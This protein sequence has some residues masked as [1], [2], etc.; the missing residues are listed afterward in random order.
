MRLSSEDIINYRP[1]SSCLI[2]IPHLD[3]LEGCPDSE[4]LEGRRTRCRVRGRRPISTV[5]SRFEAER[6]RRGNQVDRRKVQV[7][8]VIL[9]GIGVLGITKLKRSECDT[10]AADVEA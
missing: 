7:F 6:E 3:V 2:L 5:T 10:V 8:I 1:S 4:G 9:D